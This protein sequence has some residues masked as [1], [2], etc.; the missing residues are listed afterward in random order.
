[1][2]TPLHAIALFFALLSIAGPVAARLV[3]QLRVAHLADVAEEV[4][5]E[6]T[7]GIVPTRHHLERQAAALCRCASCDSDSTGRDRPSWDFP[8]PIPALKGDGIP[9]ARGPDAGP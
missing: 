8:K 1:M 4:G 9:I 3:L 2:K 6:R 5:G 7:E